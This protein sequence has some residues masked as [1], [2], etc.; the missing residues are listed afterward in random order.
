MFGSDSDGIVVPPPVSVF[1]QMIRGVPGKGMGSERPLGGRRLRK[2]DAVS[3]EPMPLP[4]QKQG[5][6]K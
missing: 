4:G 1:Y 5:G 3:D 6:N 2:R